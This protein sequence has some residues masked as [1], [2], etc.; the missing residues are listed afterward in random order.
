MS[1]VQGIGMGR[2]GETSSFVPVSGH[3]QRR[4]REDSALPVRPANSQP[5]KPLEMSFDQLVEQVEQANRFFL[6]HHTHLE[7]SIHKETKAI[8]VRIINSETQE[9]IKEIPP[10]KILDLV[11][12]LW[13]MAGLLIDERR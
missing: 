4:V 2:A 10:E 8:I 5:D 11:A 6:N 9:V 3:G 13:E 1:A 12:K 7:F